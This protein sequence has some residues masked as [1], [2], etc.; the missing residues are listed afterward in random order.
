MKDVYKVRFRIF[1]RGEMRL[2]D[3]LTG[4]GLDR[5]VDSLAFF[6]SLLDVHISSSNYVMIQ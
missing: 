2:G 4:M 1:W 3:I 6:S 5:F